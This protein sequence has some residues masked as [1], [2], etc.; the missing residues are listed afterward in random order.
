MGYYAEGEIEIYA[1]EETAIIMELLS[2]ELNR[3]RV[4]QRVGTECWH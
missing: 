1:T 2:D 3:A 4:R